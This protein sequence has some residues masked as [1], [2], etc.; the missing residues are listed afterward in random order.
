MSCGQLTSG[1]VEV[2]ISPPN[3][4]LFS[5]EIHW[6]EVTYKSAVAS[7]PLA[8]THD[9]AYVDGGQTADD[10]MTNVIA[11]VTYNVLVK[12]RS[13]HLTSRDSISTICTAGQFALI[14]QQIDASLFFEVVFFWAR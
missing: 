4:S 1:L 14:P 11:G 10:N 3:A 12:S 9:V 6:Y 13:G 2:E 8:V 7:H 5:F